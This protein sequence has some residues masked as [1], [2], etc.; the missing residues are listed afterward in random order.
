MEEENYHYGVEELVERYPAL[1]VCKESIL[2][3]Y[4][5]LETCFST[6]HKLLLCGNGGSCADSEHIAGELMKGFK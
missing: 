2:S 4:Q 6:G 3:A 1:L 5:L